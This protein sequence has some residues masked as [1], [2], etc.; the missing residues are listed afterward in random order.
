M[1]ILVNQGS[2]PQD[3][4]QVGADSC[5]EIEVKAASK[6]MIEVLRLTSPRYVL[7]TAITIMQPL[8][9]FLGR[10]RDIDISQ[11]LSTITT[12]NY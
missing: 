11:R 6:H 4:Q 1:M 10:E 12:T 7:L 9:I 3:E 5:P 8:L 2:R